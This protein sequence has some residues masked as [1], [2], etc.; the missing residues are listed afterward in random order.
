LVLFDECLELAA[1]K[2]LEQL[3]EQ[4]GGLSPWAVFGGIT[5]LVKA[6]AARTGSFGL[7]LSGGSSSS[8]VFRDVTGLV[9]GQNYEISAWVRRPSGM[10][11]A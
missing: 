11:T 9:P 7:E 5:A 2:M 4:A 1:G 10:G 3:I 8:G 6:S